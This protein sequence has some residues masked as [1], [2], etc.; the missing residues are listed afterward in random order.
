M[1]F[2]K[3]SLKRLI[4]LYVKIIINF[5]TN[6]KASVLM[7]FLKD[8]DYRISNVP[9]YCQF[10]S[11]DLS[12]DILEGKI[13]TI[14]DPNLSIF[15]FNSNEEAAYWSWRICG[16]CC[17]KM[18]L[19]YYNQNVSIAELTKKGISL[20]GYDVESDK[21]WYHVP[22]CNLARSYG[23]ECLNFNYVK[24]ANI[25]NKIRNHQ[26]VIASVNPE[27]IRGDNE[28]GSLEKG[29]HFVLITGVRLKD[30]K[31]NGFYIHNPSGD[32]IKSRQDAYIKIDRFLA[33]YSMRSIILHE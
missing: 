5:P 1:N 14:N 13:N 15:G 26:F 8:S 21:G 24:P 22:L 2:D 32:T 6:A 18:V 33:A 25:A 30:H 4:K 29:G 16:I 12:K 31:I 23:L 7:L 28:I 9:Y 11:P 10:A 3:I 27:I 19:N 17:L 20:G